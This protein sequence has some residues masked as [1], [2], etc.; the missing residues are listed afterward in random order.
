[1]RERSK[2]VMVGFAG[3]VVAAAFCC[4]TAGG[5]CRQPGRRTDSA[6]PAPVTP[7]PAS[8]AVWRAAVRAASTCHRS[9]QHRWRR[10]HRRHDVAR[11]PG[12]PCG[13]Q[14]VFRGRWRPAAHD[15]AGTGRPQPAEPRRDGDGGG[16]APGGQRR[17]ASRAGGRTDRRRRRSRLRLRVRRRSLGAHRRDDGGVADGRRTGPRHRGRRRPRPRGAPPR[18]RHRHLRPAPGATDRHAARDLRIAARPRLRRDG[19]SG[20]RR[21]RRRRADQRP[22]GRRRRGSLAA[23]ATRSPRRR[24]RWVAP[25]GD[26]LPQRRAADRRGQRDGFE[27][28]VAAFV[29]DAAGAQRADV[30]RGRGLAHDAHRRRRRRGAAPARRGRHDP[31][32]PRRLRRRQSVRRHRSSRGHHRRA[33]WNRQ[34]GSRAAGPG[35]GGGH[36][37]LAGRQRRSRSCRWATRR[38]SR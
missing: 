30:Q 7:V 4:T 36:G 35:A 10:G 29:R 16:R 33:G 34:D 27:H 3:T 26:P 5:M 22:G 13:H 15:D 25:A 19:R 23:V 28:D 38:I 1:M 32:R 14:L 37:D 8:A 9:G 21:V 6:P 17:D 24:G 20:A 31:A 11:E 12:R 2:S 18:R